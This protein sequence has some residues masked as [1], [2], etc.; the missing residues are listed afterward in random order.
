[1]DAAYYRMVLPDSLY[2]MAT[3]NINIVTL[4]IYN[5]YTIVIYDNV[6]QLMKTD[7]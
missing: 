5:K 4:N 1:M 6:T 2:I 7:S 3:S